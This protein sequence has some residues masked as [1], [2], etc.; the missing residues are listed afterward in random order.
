MTDPRAIMDL[1][2]RTRAEIK[3]GIDPNEALDGLAKDLYAEME[4]KPAKK[5]K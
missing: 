3:S 5:K 4:E 1:L 2:D